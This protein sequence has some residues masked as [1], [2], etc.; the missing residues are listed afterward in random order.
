MPELPEVETTVNDLRPQL[1]G[2]QIVAAHVLWPRTVAEPDA[3]SLA[4]LLPGQH[5]LSLSRRGKYLLFA[6]ESGMTLICHLRMT[7]RLRVEPDGGELPRDPHTR[8]W[9]DLAGVEGQGPQRLVF[10]DA[11]KFGRFWLVS[12]VQGVLGA[13]GPE[14]LA[15]DFTPAVLRERL[16]G[17]HVAIKA[18]L[19]DQHVVAGLGNIY[20]DEALFSAGIHPLRSATALENGEIDRLHAAIIRVLR[21]AVGGRGTTLRDYRPPYGDRGSFQEKLRVYQRTGQPCVCCGE[22]ICRIRVTQ[23]STH[24]CPHCQT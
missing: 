17:R 19:L 12:D 11:R 7:G 10:S 20:A 9:F 15:P 4:A 2:R 24:F 1:L 3:G 22:P 16:Q 13:L 6:L 14:P 8:A 21:A 18:L 23:R 5:I